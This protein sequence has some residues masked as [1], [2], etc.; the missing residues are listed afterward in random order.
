[1]GSRG[2]TTNLRR[3]KC[4]ERRKTEHLRDFLGSG[5]LSYRVV[6]KFSSP[7]SALN[8]KDNNKQEEDFKLKP[9]I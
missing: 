6:P 8:S 3:K 7:K 1:M 4:A 2:E 9:H 5:N